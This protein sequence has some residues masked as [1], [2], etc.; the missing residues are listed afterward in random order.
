MTAWTV[1]Y[2]EVGSYTDLF[3]GSDVRVSVTPQVRQG[4]SG[5]TQPQGNGNG[6]QALLGIHDVDSLYMIVGSLHRAPTT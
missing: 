3:T 1:T 4:S 5:E 6:Q 2:S